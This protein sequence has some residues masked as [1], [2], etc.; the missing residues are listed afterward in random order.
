ME[1]VDDGLAADRADEQRVAVGRALRRRL[2]ADGGAGAGLVFDDHR[3]AQAQGELFPDRAGD[4]V[5]TAARWERRDEADRARRVLLCESRRAEQHPQENE[6]AASARIH[7]YIIR[8]AASV[9]ARAIRALDALHA[10]DAFRTLD[11]LRTLGA[12]HALRTLGP[13]GP[14]RTLGAVGAAA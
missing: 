5:D 6:D 10:L 1:V 3:L 14:L 4:D 2:G 9:T 12:L 13:L 8:D 11:P 7:A